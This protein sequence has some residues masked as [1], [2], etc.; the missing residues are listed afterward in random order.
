[1]ASEALRM[2]QQAAIPF[3][4]TSSRSCIAPAAPRTASCA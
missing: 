4:V 1:M 3:K 2:A